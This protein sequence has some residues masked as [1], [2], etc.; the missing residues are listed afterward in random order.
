M[1]QIVS[2]SIFFGYEYFRLAASTHF[3]SHQHANFEGYQNQRE[4][5]K[6]E[7]FQNLQYTQVSEFEK[8]DSHFNPASQCLVLSFFLFIMRYH[9]GLNIL[10]KIYYKSLK[11]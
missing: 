8:L 1:I 4:G 11:K 6:Q 9:E 2:Y 5:H 10:I 3:L 7:G